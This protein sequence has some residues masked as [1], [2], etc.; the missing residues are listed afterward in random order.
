MS[1]LNKCTIIGN[2][3]KPPEIRSFAN[4]GKVASFSVAVSEYWRDKN[5]GERKERTEW[6]NISVLNENLVKVVENYVTKGTKVYVEGQLETRKWKDKEGNDRYS[7]EVVLRPYRGEIILLSAR[8][9]SS[10][11]DEP[12]D[13]AVA[14]AINSAI[15]EDFDDDLPF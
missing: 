11:Q 4:G 14:P 15:P 5:S 9:G 7:T 1:S 2:V 12:E 3:G 13:E 10:R 8:E 6:I